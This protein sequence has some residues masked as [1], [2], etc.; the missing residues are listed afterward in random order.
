M[1]N[2]VAKVATVT[3]GATAVICAA[4]IVKEMTEDVAKAVKVFFK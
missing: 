2:I 4:V 1:I 3:V